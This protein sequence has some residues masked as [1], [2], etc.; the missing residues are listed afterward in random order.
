M[1]DDHAHVTAFALLRKLAEL[2]AFTAVDR[3]AAR[4]FVDHYHPQP[5]NYANALGKVGHHDQPAEHLVEINE[6]GFR[7]VHPLAERDQPDP[8][9]VFDCELDTLLRAQGGQPRARGRY[10]V[11]RRPAPLDNPAREIDRDWSWRR[12]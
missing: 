11:V 1:L 2:E 9:A 4:E 12:G 6:A 5:H 8:F 7:L 10:V 3:L